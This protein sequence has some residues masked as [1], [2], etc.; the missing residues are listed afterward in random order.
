MNLT[1]DNKLLADE[2][3]RKIGRNVVTFQQIEHMLKAILANHQISGFANELETNIR[4][5]KDKFKGQTMGGL[6]TQL[7]DQ[8]LTGTLQPEAEPTEVKEPWISVRHQ[9]SVGSEFS[10]ELNSDLLRITSARNELIHHF[11]PKWQPDSHDALDQA[12]IYLDDQRTQILPLHEKLKSILQKMVQSS[13][14]TAN[15]MAGV[16][17]EWLE[18]QWLQTSELITFLRDLASK[19]SKSS[20]WIYLAGAGSVA[21][22]KC[23]EDWGNLERIYG[24]SSLKEILIACELFEVDDEVMSNGHVR[25]RY[26]LKPAAKSL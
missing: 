24:Y 22:E 10:D 16:G 18:L 6:A 3:L 5:R 4:L 8:V 26:R 2:V 19:K 11:L 12:C 25:T 7:V 23:S 15:F 20:G 1:T 14:V 17:G 13:Q 21:K 9:L